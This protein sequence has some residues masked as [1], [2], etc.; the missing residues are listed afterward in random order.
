MRDLVDTVDSS[1]SMKRKKARKLVI[2]HELKSYL[3]YDNIY[4]NSLTFCTHTLSGF[5]YIDV[6]YQ[7]NY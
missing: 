3:P 6:I 2:R 5:I 4:R 1:Y 7:T